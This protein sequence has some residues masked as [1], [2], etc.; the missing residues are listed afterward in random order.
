MVCIKDSMVEALLKNE[1]LK[2]RKL[3]EE[4]NQTILSHCNNRPRPIFI[5]CN[6]QKYFLF[7]IT[8]LLHV[9]IESMPPNSNITAILNSL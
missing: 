7:F 8:H 4:I 6:C 3:K 2:E 5:I 1:I 9:L